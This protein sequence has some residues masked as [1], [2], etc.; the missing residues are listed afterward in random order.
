MPR[1]SDCSPPF[2]LSNQK[3][4]RIS[5]LPMRTICPVHLILPCLVTLIF[6]EE[7]KLWSSLLCSFLQYPVTS[8]LVVTNILLSTLFSNTLI[9]C[10]SLYVRDQVSHPY[11]TTG[12]I[13]F[14]YI[15]I[16]TFLDSKGENKIF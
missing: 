3:F 7:Y 5:H 12:K 16:F 6:G 9:L 13:I 1:S 8:S 4:V 11:R 14:L 2:R 15:L 10:S